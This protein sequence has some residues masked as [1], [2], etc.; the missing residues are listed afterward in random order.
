MS[1]RN[2]LPKGRGEM[3][4]TIY[5]DFRCL[6]DP[7]YQYRGIGHHVSALL[8]SQKSR[9][10]SWRTIGLIEPA[11]PALPAKYAA[12]VDET[13]C[14]VNPS[15]NG[16]PAIFLDA[17]PM[18]HDPRFSLRFQNRHGLL[19]VTV[20]YDFIPFDW[21]GYLPKVADHIAYLGKLARLKKV[22]HFFPISQYIAW[23]L[24]ELLGVSGVGSCHRRFGT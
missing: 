5:A 12:L 19:R 21:P 18:T 6:Q 14:S 24:S 23:R 17:S 10:S 11:L 9:L 15:L 22:D 2:Y 7:N 8:R 13:S 16:A 20:V 4:G 1:W 3:S